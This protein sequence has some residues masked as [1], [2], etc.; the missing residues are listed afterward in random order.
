MLLELPLLL[1]S[2]SLPKETSCLIQWFPVL[3]ESGCIYILF[4][5]KKN[6]KKKFNENVY[7]HCSLKMH[8]FKP[9]FTVNDMVI[10]EKSIFVIKMQILCEISSQ[11][12]ITILYSNIF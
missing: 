3:G 1:V 10:F 11:F 8:V 4:P 12:K 6:K 9:H 2:F 5:V 7:T